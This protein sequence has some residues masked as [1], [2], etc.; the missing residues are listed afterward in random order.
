VKAVQL[1]RLDVARL[2]DVDEPEP[3]RGDLIV[4]VSAAGM[5][6]SDRHLVSGDYPAEPPVILGHEFEG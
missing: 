3:G 6:G 4:R 2:V 5:C 1:E